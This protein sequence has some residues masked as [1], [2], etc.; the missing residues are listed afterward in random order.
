MKE[1]LHKELTEKIIGCF[2]GVYNKLG[3]GFL[4]KVYE[5]ALVIE[6]RKVGLKF[7][8]QVPIQVVYD[9]EIVG[10]YVAD[11]I[12][13]GKVVVEVKASKSL[14]TIDEAQLINYLKATGIRVGLLL[15]FGKEAEIKRRVFD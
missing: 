3:Y 1:D 15:N 13:E 5:N 4:E 6:F 9:D 8:K 10:E 14:G 11:F 7:G 2:Y 12:V